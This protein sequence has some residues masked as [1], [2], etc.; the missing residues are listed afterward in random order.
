MFFEF[1]FS[2]TS[3]NIENEITTFLDSQF[4][5]L[6]EY[7]NFIYQKENFFLQIKQLENKWM[8]NVSFSASSSYGYN[9]LESE[10]LVHGFNYNSSLNFSQKIPLGILFNADLFSFSGNLKEQEI[11]HQYNYIGKLEFFIIS[12][13]I[14]EI[15]VCISI[16]LVQL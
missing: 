9:P 13:V 16:P 7:K 10:N 4:V 6:Y 5:S 8:P 1:I 12:I 3:K 14:P 2:S 15:S 11:L